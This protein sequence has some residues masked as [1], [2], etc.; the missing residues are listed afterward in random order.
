[1]LTHGIL[2]GIPAIPILSKE[3]VS[4]DVRLAQLILLV[5]IWDIESLDPK[6]LSGLELWIGQCLK[7]AGYGEIV[8]G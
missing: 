8:D 3:N 6:T 1:M 5:S 7:S 2:K 4:L